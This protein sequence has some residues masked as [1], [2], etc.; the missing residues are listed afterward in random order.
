MDHALHNQVIENFYDAF[1]RKDV[2]TMLSCYHLQVE[3]TDPAFGTL[4]GDDARDMWRMLISNARQLEV[5]YAKVRA[6][7]NTGS[8]HWVAKYVF[9]KTGRSITNH[10]SATFEFKDGLIYRHRDQFDMWLWSRQAFGL[11]GLFLGWTPWMRKKV[12]A[13]A[14][15]SLKAFQSRGQR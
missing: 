13:T 6:D 14:R 10:I 3:F 8:A 15:A 12:Q 9:S 4:Q 7:E 5:M 1:G 11:A 2:D